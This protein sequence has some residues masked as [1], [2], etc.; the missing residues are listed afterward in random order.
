MSSSSANTTFFTPEES[1]TLLLDE[2]AFLIN[3]VSTGVSYGIVI[4]IF[5]QLLPRIFA[6]SLHGKRLAL[7]LSI[8]SSL[9]FILGTLFLVSNLIEG[10]DILNPNR[11]KPG[12]PIGIASVSA[13]NS[14]GALL[15]CIISVIVCCLADGLMVY[16]CYIFFGSNLLYCRTA[17]CH[18]CRI[19]H[20]G[21]YCTHTAQTSRLPVS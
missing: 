2:L 17:C 13:S 1:R 8:Y 5:T 9:I 18:V 20:H 15:D 14:N 10:I 12:G 6:R 4:A 19:S 3:Q 21:R 7:P 11:N 16:R